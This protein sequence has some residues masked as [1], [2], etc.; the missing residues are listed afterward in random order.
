MLIDKQN[1]NNGH[2]A[3][4]C[5]AV[6][7]RWSATT[8]SQIGRW[9]PPAKRRKTPAYLPSASMAATCAASASSANG[10]PTTA[11]PGASASSSAA[12]A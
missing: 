1:G 8:G 4:P 6:M 5:V 7:Q 2:P 10:L 11:I 3:H 12:P 9:Q